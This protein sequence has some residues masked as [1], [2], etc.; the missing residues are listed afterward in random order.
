M[1]FSDRLDAH[2]VGIYAA[3]DQMKGV[4]GA[5]EKRQRRHQD[6]RRSKDR[7]RGRWCAYEEVKVTGLPGK[8]AADVSS[9]GG[10]LA[11]ASVVARPES[12]QPAG[13]FETGTGAPRQPAILQN[14]RVIVS[15]M[16]I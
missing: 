2:V 15:C 11:A 16:L 6:S 10:R 13:T 14:N 5:N 9:S 8:T 3:V 7:R 1:F 4:S 12:P